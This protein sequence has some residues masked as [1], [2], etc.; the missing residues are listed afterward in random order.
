MWKT[1][2]AANSHRTSSWLRHCCLPVQPVEGLFRGIVV[3]ENEADVD[4]PDWGRETLVLCAG[5]VEWFA[6]F[7]VGGS[8]TWRH[9]SVFQTLRPSAVQEGAGC[10]TVALAE[11]PRIAIRIAVAITD[12]S[13]VSVRSTKSA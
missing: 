1:D 3:S 4:V 5:G 10:V 6:A 9:V 13:G 11:T 2:W 12:T 8:Q 7:E